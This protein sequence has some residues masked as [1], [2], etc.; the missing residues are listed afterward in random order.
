MAYFNAKSA[1][2]DRILGLRILE[3]RRLLGW[4]QSQLAAELT[5]YGYFTQ[6]STISKWEKGDSVPSG[7]A[8]LAI[9]CAM[10]VENGLQYFSGEIPSALDSRGQKKLR[11]YENDL[12]ASGLY[13]PAPVMPHNNIIE[14]RDIPFP[15]QAISAGTGNF[16]DDTQQI[17]MISFPVDSIPAGA[18]YGMH[19]G[20]DSMEPVF[21]DQSNVFVKVCDQL[22]PGDVGVFIYDGWSYIKVYSEEIDPAT[23]YT[24]PVLI[25]YNPNYAPIRVNSEL[26]FRIFGKVLRH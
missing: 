15:I 16:L 17:E 11:D 10:K 1:A 21:P 14:F 12:I 19:V 5:K 18:D 4:N 23:G 24:I 7:Y 26:N 25:S 9:C 20:G 8:L 3:R 6:K 13:K 2:E 22:S